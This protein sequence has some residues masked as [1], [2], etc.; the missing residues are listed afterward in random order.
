MSAHTPGPWWV[1]RE[2]AGYECPGIEAESVS[3]VV[4]GERLEDSGQNGVQ[5]NTTDEAKANARLIA[6]APA[7][8]KFAENMR[9]THATDSPQHREACAVIALATGPTP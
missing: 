4:F 5:G 1:Y 2:D 7:L 6:A 3:I 8:L 9:D